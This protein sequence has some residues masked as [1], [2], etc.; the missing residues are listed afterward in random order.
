[1]SKPI[2]ARYVPQL[3]DGWVKCPRF[4]DPRFFEGLNIIP[5]KVPLGRHFDQ[6]T[7]ASGRWTLADAIRQFRGY[8]MEVATVIDLTKSRNYYHIG[9]EMDELAGMHLPTDINYVKIECR[10]RGES[11][12]PAEVNEAVWH[13]FIHSVTPELQNKYILLHCTHGFNRTGFV[14]VSALMRLRKDRGLSVRRALQRFAAARPPGIYKDAYINDLFKYYHETRE[15]RV[16]T[17]R[18]PAWKGN[19]DAEDAADAANEDAGTEEDGGAAAPPA[20]EIHHE[21]I[22]SI[23]ERVCGEEAEWIKMQVC[24][25]LRLDSG[26]RGGSLRF[27]GMQPVSL[28]LERMADLAAHRYHVTWKA[29]GTRYMML[30]L[31]QGTYIM[32]R[33]FNVVRCE[34]RFPCGSKRP[35]PGQKAAYPVGRPHNLTLLDGEMV[36]DV[37]PTGQAP[38]R[39]RYLIYDVCMIN[40]TPLLQKPWKERYRAIDSDIVKPRTTERAYIDDW[41]RPGRGAW[42]PARAEYLSPPLQYDYA[43]EAFSVRQK[44][45]WPVHQIDKVFERFHD[46]H[47]VGHESDGLIL[48]GYEHQY[49]PGTCELLYKWKFAHMNSVDFKLRCATVPDPE[50]AADPASGRRPVMLDPAHPAPLTLYLL[51][52]NK[53]RGSNIVDVP[54]ERIDPHGNFHVEFPPGVDPLDYDGKLCECTFDRERGVWLFMRERKDKDTA[55]GSRVYLRI[56]ESII[57]HVDQDLLVGTLKDSLINRPEYASDRAH[58][59]PAE[60]EVLR[61]DVEAWRERQHM[62]YEQQQ[63]QQHHPPPPGHGRGAGAG[64]AGQRGNGHAAAGAGGGAGAAYGEGEDGPQPL[65]P[66]GGDPHGNDDDYHGG[67]NDGGTYKVSDA[68][69]GARAALKRKR[70]P[71]DGEGGEGGHGEDGHGGVPR[72][73]TTVWGPEIDEPHEHCPAYEGFGF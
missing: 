50:A 22:W 64:G 73:R 54:L 53:T 18:V 1:M 6:Q 37:D 44:P 58:L 59:G 52:Q 13:I 26:G 66:P 23:G 15:P 41:R 29:D 51:D 45:F 19:D 61:R 69:D 49:V 68:D 10:G 55:N 36:V 33:S 62:Q 31:P 60:L 32:D 38:P 27:P 43:A 40:A 2:L 30:L 12:R 3:P 28:S 70:D 65:S 16:L 56:K 48:Q 47:K 21:D 20:K 9:K 63:M 14:I 4:G 42:D 5:C 72:G 24:G 46:P 8:G 67:D 34:M 39:L 25:L 35:P 71:G 7:G 57:N 17:P 11:P